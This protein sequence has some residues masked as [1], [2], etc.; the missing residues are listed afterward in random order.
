MVQAATAARGG[1]A[2][3]GGNGGGGDAAT[4]NGG[5][6]EV[7]AIPESAAQPG[8]AVPVRSLASTV[9]QA[10]RPTFGGNGGNGR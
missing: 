3:D 2:G 7:A 6:A 8:S 9:Q 10:L 4:P 1:I 5:S